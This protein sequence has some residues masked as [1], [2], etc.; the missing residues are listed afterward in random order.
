NNDGNYEPN[1]CKWASRKEQQR[2]R[3]GII[4][5]SI[6]GKTY[7]AID[8]SDDYGIKVD[9]IVARTN[10]GLSFSEVISK[11]KR[12]FREGLSLGGLANGKR[13]KEKTHCKNG[14]EYNEK[15]TYISK[16][17]WRLCKR[18]HADREQKRRK[19]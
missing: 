4:F 1:N 19:D 11:Q 9:T 12:V 17:G 8:L 7:K 5:V 16:E 3:R 14:H 15:N 18:C 2:N 6:E 10:I 13:Q